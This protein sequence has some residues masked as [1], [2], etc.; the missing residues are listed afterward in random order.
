MNNFNLRKFL[1]ENKLTGNSKVLN[2]VAEN[3]LDAVFSSLND[4]TRAGEISGEEFDVAKS[5]LES[6]PASLTPFEK[7]K[8]VQAA[9]ESLLNEQEDWQ[10]KEWKN[11]KLLLEVVEGLQR[12]L[13]EIEDVKLW[14]DQT[15]NDWCYDAIEQFTSAAQTIMGE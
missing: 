4:M 3:F 2:E 11:R 7:K 5:K 9:A 1:A 13:E 8:D 12:E 14:D 6:N 10:G 15:S